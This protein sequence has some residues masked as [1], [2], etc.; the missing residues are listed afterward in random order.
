M[1]MKQTFLQVRT[2]LAAGLL[3]AAALA[4]CSEDPSGQALGG[5][6]ALQPDDRILGA[7]DAPV[8]VIEYAS[9]TCG[10]CAGFHATAFKALKEQYIDTGKVRW[11]LRE[12][13]TPPQDRAVAGF[14]LAR[15]LPEDRYFAFVD[16][17]FRTQQQ[18][19]TAPNASEELRRIARSAGMSDADFNACLSDDAAIQR[20]ADVTETGNTTYGVD[21]TPSFIIDGR[22][23]TNMP[24]Q[25][26]VA[27]L[28]PLVG[29]AEETAADENS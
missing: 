3:A 10:A 1:L 24:L 18:W 20:I 17:L 13:P 16:V 6:V 26:F 27:I 28:D 5:A 22:K 2:L 14:M 23:Y 29:A 11:V 9:L 12:F 19:V 21:S 15:C 4:G 8:T 7:P 25:D